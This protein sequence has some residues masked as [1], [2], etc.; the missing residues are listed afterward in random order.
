M[1]TNRML[2]L[3]TLLAAGAALSGCATTAGLTG[4]RT[5]DVQVQMAETIFLD[6]AGP[7]D[8]RVI[9]YVRNTSDKAGMD[10]EAA[11]KRAVAANGWRIVE[12]PADA[13]YVLQANVLAVGEM[14]PDSLSQSLK[15]GFAGP[16]GT[17]AA[18]AGA[19]LLGQLGDRRIAAT[20]LLAATADAV[21]S[22]FVRTVTYGVVA[23]LQL[24][25][26]AGSPGAVRVQGSQ[27]LAQGSG[28]SEQH[29]YAERSD[30]KRFRTRLVAK[31]E[32]TNLAWE[33]AEP[34]LSSGIARSV[35]GLL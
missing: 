31:A 11:V 33:E 7:A 23:D 10:L 15:A 1:K 13:A 27:R 12:D 22:T 28:G 34:R 19:G 2:C 14:T 30:W 6:P 3:G 9:V 16:I 26:R 8:R 29:Q 18:V 25:Q 17:G 20:A 21:A 32:K 35:A 5:L 4:G 24:A